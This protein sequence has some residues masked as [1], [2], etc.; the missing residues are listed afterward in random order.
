MILQD[1]SPAALVAAIEEN[2]FSW[3]PIFGNL[4]RAC[5]DDPP[6]VIRSITDL[7]LSLFNSVMDAR[8]A[9]DQ[10]D[11]AIERVLSEAGE[12]KVPLLW[13]TG[14]S[15]RPADLGKRLEERGFAFDEESPGMAADLANLNEGLPAPHGLRIALARDDASWQLCG[16]IMGLG[17]EVPAAKLDVMANAW[18]QLLAQADPETTLAYIGWWNGEPVATSLL[19]L[20]GG[21]AGIYAVGTIPAARRRGIG[22]QM[23]LHPLIHARRMGYRVGVLGASEMGFGVYRSLGFQEYCRLR[24]YVWRP[25]S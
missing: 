9:P 2:L 15:T 6:G 8:L 7:P 4:G 17:F 23:T 24:E 3:V 10:V 11:P 20:G 13:W 19:Q 1:L 25:P 21:V 16:R 22:A 14:P 18:H 5:A 12:R